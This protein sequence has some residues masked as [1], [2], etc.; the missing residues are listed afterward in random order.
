MPHLLFLVHGM[1]A[2]PDGWEQPVVS[3]LAELYDRYEA[4]S[5][6]PIADRLSIV[7]IGYDAIFR[8]ILKEWAEANEEIG[9]KADELEA[10][11]VSQLVSWLQQGDLDDFAWSHA[12]DVLLY[13]GFSLVRERVKVA[14]ALAMA[15]DIAV[16][17]EADEPWSVLAHS[18]GTAITHDSL[19]ALF[20]S[21]IPSA[22][23]PTGFAP[24]QAQAN[25]VC[26][27]A[28]VSR[29]L[30]TVPPAYDSA[31]KPGPP[32]AGGRGCQLFL[33]FAHKLD[34]FLVPE[35]F[36]P[37]VWPD[38]KS[39]DEVFF[40]RIPRLE[41]IHRVDVHSWLHYLEHPRVHIPLFRAL[42]WKAAITQQE[43]AEALAAFPTIGPGLGN[44]W[45][46]A[47]DR[48]DGAQVAEPAATWKSFPA[49][50]DAL[51]GA[52]EWAR[53]EGLPV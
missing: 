50:W 20:T 19:H 46:D 49:I 48:L 11:Q 34:P 38:G 26:T 53:G 37:I 27:L 2:H 13:R 35:P 45:Q 16:A 31:V 22:D 4:L 17:I 6:K 36:D 3:K 28:N 14:V 5:R 51:E 33:N 12:A 10:G 52:R 30:Q 24:H 43:E 47:K 1:G 32:G 29:A 39:T 21:A 25:V 8:E 23:L 7:P 40:P 9:S 15:R 44:R 42:T 41:H 18:L